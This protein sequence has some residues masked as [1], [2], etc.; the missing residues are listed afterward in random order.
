MSGYIGVVKFF[1]NKNKFGFIIESKTRAEY[2]FHAKDA[3]E[4]IIE[5]DAV[6]FD[7]SEQK[8]GPVCVH[9]KKLRISLPPD[10]IPLRY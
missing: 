9:I 8:K 6:S 7:L 3:D 10:R 4:E 1:S 2:Y 5:G